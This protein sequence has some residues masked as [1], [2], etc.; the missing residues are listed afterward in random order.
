MFNFFAKNGP[1][2]G[3][4]CFFEGHFYATKIKG[5]HEVP[6]LKGK[7]RSVGEGFEYDKDAID[8]NATYGV[9][10]SNLELGT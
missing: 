5:G 2:D 3:P 8:H 10:V 9:G 7:L 6:D 4:V 1:Y